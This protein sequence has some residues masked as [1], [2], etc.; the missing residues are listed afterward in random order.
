MQVRKNRVIE[1]KAV[2]KVREFFEAHNCI[3]QEVNLGNDFG[4]D[5]Y[6]DLVEDGVV[7]GICFAIQIKGGVS[8]KRSDGFGIPLDEKHA[9]LWRNSN[10]PVLGAV[11]SEQDDLVR[12]CNISSFLTTTSP[13]YPSHI[14][15]GSEDILESGSLEKIKHS[16]LTIKKGKKHPVLNLLSDSELERQSAVYDCFALGRNDPDVF[17]S[18]RYMLPSLD[19][20]QLRTAVTALSHLG[21]HPDIMWGPH[22]W[23]SPSVKEKVRPHFI[24]NIDEII[25]LLSCSSWDEW[26]RG[27]IGEDVYVL[28]IEDPEIQSKIENAALRAINMGESDAAF[29]AFYLS[30]FWAGVNGLNKFEE[31]V[32]KRSEFS[33]FDLSGEVFANLIEFG[34]VSLF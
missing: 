14:P 4:K 24:W 3:F 21:L 33:K 13:P 18:L 19:N 12:W 9:R 16:V 32:A 30:V 15:I 25:L 2:S 7:T 11:Y 29:S 10:V 28:L 5:A 27:A 20:L 34:F 1:R 22:N 6:V 8:Y 26:N 23:I 31:L 17:I